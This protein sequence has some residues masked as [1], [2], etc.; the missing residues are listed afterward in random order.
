[1]GKS[2][3]KPIANILIGGVVFFVVVAAV[4][5]L[6]HYLSSGSGKDT[7]ILLLIVG[8]SIL[9]MGALG[10]MGMGY[11]MLALGNSSEAFALPEG[12]VRALIALML[13]ILF[14]ISMMHVYGSL[15]NAN[16]KSIPAVLDPESTNNLP[17]GFIRSSDKKTVY[18]LEGPSQAGVDFAK[19]LL[20]MFATLITSITSFYFG[21]RSSESAA[22]KARVE[23]A[24]K[25]SVGAN[26]SSESA[27]SKARAESAAKD[28]GVAKG[29]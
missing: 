4:I 5:Y 25:G 29:T 13:I 14:S 1:M 22:S 15:S 12:S 20:T 6:L 16:M 9:V 18:Y 27:A 10:F 28:S 21:A 24:V 19:Q 7:I 11:S 17:Q 8:C 3:D 26:E 23:T 2:L